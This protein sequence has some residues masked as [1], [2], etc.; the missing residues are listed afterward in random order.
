[1]TWTPQQAHQWW[2]Q[3]PLPLGCN[4]IPSTAINQLDMWQA[5]SYDP[6]TIERE[7]GFAE[8]LGMNT[9]RVYLHN[10]LWEE[11]PDGFKNR[12]RHFLQLVE[13]HRL[14]ALFV[15]F[16]SC[17]N[18]HP[19]LGPQPAPRPGVHNSGWLQAPGSRRIHDPESWPALQ[20]Y[21]QDV[22]TSFQHDPRV[23][24]W[25]LFNEPTQGG[26]RDTILPLLTSVFNWAQQVRPDQPLTVAL[27]EQHEPSNTL[28]LERSDIVTFHHY[29]PADR[30][31]QEIE[32]L[33][34]HR[35]P[36]I[37]SEY[38]ARQEGST[39]A[40]CLPVLRRHRVGALNW[41]LVAGKTNT[42]FPWNHT[43]EQP[44]DLWFHDVLHPDGTP[45]DPT[46]VELLRS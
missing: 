30:L 38:M 37:C 2:N 4:F 17:W 18:D 11:D 7:L 35:R 28:I 14:Q 31:E 24:G 44:P 45:F 46:E 26:H 21:V 34:K 19:Q 33:Q 12:I 41:G 40:A 29:G 15:L 8:N 27:W 1:M 23:L 20:G 5:Q 25:D 43:G 42:I 36:L 13:G 16:D 6:A 32:Q 9:L 10:L 3:R 39:F 22:L